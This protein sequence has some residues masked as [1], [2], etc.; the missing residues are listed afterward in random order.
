MSLNNPLT[1]ILPKLNTPSEILNR[2]TLNSPQIGTSV[3]GNIPSLVTISPQSYFLQQMESWISSPS[4][5]T[6]WV[7][8][9]D[10][11]PK[12]LK[13]EVIK[14]LEVTRGEGWNVP[15]EQLTNYFLQKV[16]GCI[17]AQN[18]E[19]PRERTQIKYPQSLRGFR[20]YPIAESKDP[21]MNLQLSFMETNLSF[22]DGILRPWAALVGHKG[23]VARP[24]DES[25]K[26]TMTIIQYGKT[27]PYL[28]PIA[29]KMWTFH[30]ACCVGVPKVPYNYSNDSV[31]TRTGIEFSFSSYQVYN[32]TYI[33]V[34]SLIDKFSKGGLKELTDTVVIDESI[35][36]LGKLF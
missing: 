10:D 19:I 17:F 30:D 32:T 22:V 1:N 21:H 3:L 4:N 13:T 6:Q 5:A 12:T 8:L 18:V 2:G 26:T 24:E 11:F 20:S 36:N 15:Y 9:F 16:I 35:R 27:N 14:E 23:L 29:R 25:V 28:A 33:P 31:E 7:L 34:F